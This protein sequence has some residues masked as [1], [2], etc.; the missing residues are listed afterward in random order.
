[1]EMLL[2]QRESTI[3]G[4]IDG[5]GLDTDLASHREM[6]WTT[7]SPEICPFSE[8]LSGIYDSCPF[9]AQRK[10]GKE[11]RAHDA[12][13]SYVKKWLNVLRFHA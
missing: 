12:Y 9:R 2:R 10:K 1:V 4:S 5:L 3:R 6:N 8:E 13:M 7:S 11:R